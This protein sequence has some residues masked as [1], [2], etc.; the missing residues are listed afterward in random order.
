LPRPEP[1]RLLSISAEGHRKVPYR[2]HI[3]L[4][5]FENWSIKSEFTM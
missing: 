5:S 1:S 3:S 2:V 4:S